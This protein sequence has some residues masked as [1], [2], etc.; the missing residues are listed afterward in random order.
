MYEKIADEYSVTELAGEV[1]T[2]TA[3]VKAIFEENGTYLLPGYGYFDVTGNAYELFATTPVAYCTSTSWNQ[4]QNWFYDNGYETAAAMK[5]ATQKFVE[6]CVRISSDASINTYGA[7]TAGEA[8]L[9][10]SGYTVLRQY[11]SLIKAMDAVDVTDVDAVYELKAKV[12]AFTDLYGAEAAVDGGVTELGDMANL[13]NTALKYAFV[14]EFKA[15]YTKLSAL[16]SQTLKASKADLEAY[17][18]KFDD[19]VEKYDLDKNDFAK[20]YVGAA[21]TDATYRLDTK[22]ALLC[23]AGEAAVDD[24]FNEIGKNILQAQHVDEG[25]KA[26]YD[27]FKT[28]FN[29]FLA[30]FYNVGVYE[31]DSEDLAEYQAFIMAVDKNFELRP[32]AEAKMY[33]KLQ[34]V[35]DNTKVTVKSVKEGKKVTVNASIGTTALA[36]LY[37]VYDNTGEKAFTVEYKFYHKAPGKAYKLTKTKT[38]NTITYSKALKAG[39]NSFRV[40]VVL[41]DAKGNVVAEKS[42]KASTL[43]Y[44]TIK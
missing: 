44:R 31:P 3:A 15:D 26:D 21:A 34:T 1:G 42:Y 9:D 39:K 7:M 14:S 13:W 36:N 8:N 28:A 43:A 18:K 17:A 27:A 32:V 30:D 4:L 11:K 40:G 29:A 12:K 10:A 33:A 38:A 37:N 35:L 16:T 25:E 23:N 19:F 22:L 2:S 6:A 24:A 5:A 41:K 20:A